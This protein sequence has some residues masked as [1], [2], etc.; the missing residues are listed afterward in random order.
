MIAPSRRTPPCSYCSARPF[1]C[2]EIVAPVSSSTRLMTCQA[3]T[4]STSAEPI[5]LNPNMASVILNAVSRNSLARVFTKH[6][7]G[8][9]NGVQQR[10][11]EVAVEL[12]PQTRHMDVDDIGLRIE[13]IVPHMFEQHCARDHLAG[14]LHE[15]FEQPEFAR[16]QGDL[17][18]G[19][20]HFAR[21]PVEAQIADLKRGLFRSALGAPARQR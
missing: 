11:V 9:A 8:A 5:A 17:L 14:V 21:Q 13:M 18:A 4:P 3:T 15:I 2:S 12:G 16:L 19:A 7:S 6:V 20:R 10:G 1:A